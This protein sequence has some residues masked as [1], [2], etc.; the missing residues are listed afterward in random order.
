MFAQLGPGRSTKPSTIFTCLLSAVQVEAGTQ[1]G[2]E[3]DDESEDDLQAAASMAEDGVPQGGL[4]ACAH[5][6]RLLH[7]L[8]ASGVPRRSALTVGRDAGRSRRLAAGVPA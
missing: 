3:Y 5:R 4:A 2:L 7:E 6:Y 8:W 1:P